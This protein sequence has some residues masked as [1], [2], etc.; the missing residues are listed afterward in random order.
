MA[1]L[2]ERSRSLTLP[3]VDGD[4]H[5]IGI[6]LA[7]NWSAPCKILIAYVAQVAPLAPRQ[8]LRMAI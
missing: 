7:A 8:L 1:M 4:P 5:H 3:H 2:W 6:R